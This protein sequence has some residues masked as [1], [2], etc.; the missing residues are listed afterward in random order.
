MEL[1]DHQQFL[2]SVNSLNFELDNGT[3]SILVKA[4]HLLAAIT[5]FLRT[6][7]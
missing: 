5:D 1:S 4:I 6:S 7:I 2:N 3:D